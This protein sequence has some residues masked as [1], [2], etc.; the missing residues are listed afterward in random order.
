MRYS[1]SYVARELGQDL[2]VAEVG[3]Y[4][5]INAQDM[6][7]WL[8]IKKLYLIDPF[9]EYTDRDGEHPQSRMDEAREI[10]TDRFK[11]YSAI[12]EIVVATSI[13]ASEKLKNVLFDFV[14]ID[15]CHLHPHI[16][17]DIAAWYPL[18]KVGGVLA[19]HDYDAPTVRE[20]VEG[21]RNADFR[22]VYGGGCDWVFR[23]QD[24]VRR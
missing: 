15:A 14:Y 10:T 8:H 16:D 3:V 23:R 13:E 22:R 6:L 20:A 21:F 19:G 7:D 5:G 9:Q 24:R 17:C 1:I 18:I 2:I 11:E 12:V 4:A